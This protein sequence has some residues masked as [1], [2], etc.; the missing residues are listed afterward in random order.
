MGGGLIVALAAVASGCVIVRTTGRGAP[1]AASIPA[2]PSLLAYPEKVFEPPRR[3]D[4]RYTLSNGVPVYLAEDRAFPLLDVTVLIRA[5]SYLEPR[6]KVGLAGMTATVMRTGGTASLTAEEFDEAVDFLAAFVSCSLGDVEGRASAGCLSKDADRVLDLFFEML[7]RPRFEEDRLELARTQSL[8]AMRRRNDQTG[9][10]EAREWRR[11]MRGP[12]HFSSLQSTQASIE[13]IDRADL[14]AFHQKWV[15]PANFIIAVAGDFDRQAMIDTLERHL[16]DWPA[17]ERPPAPPKPDH[18]PRAG[19]YIVNKPDVNQGRVSI[20]HVGG[21]RDNP[22]R[23]ALRVMSHILGGGGFTSRILSRVRSDEGL[24][25]S[26]GAD[27]GLGV[28]YEGLFRASFQS[29][30]PACAEA[31]DIVLQEIERIR[32]EEVNPEELATAINALA[33]APARAF[34]DARR[35]V[36]TL[37]D[38]ELNGE[39]PDYWRNYAADLKA[40]TRADVL[41]VAR[42]YLA[43]DKLVI[44]IVGNKEDI[45]KGNPDRAA[46]SMG[47]LEARFGKLEDIPL[48]DPLTLE[49]PAS[50]P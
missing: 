16:A 10:I 17:G 32:A 46:Y 31:I 42:Q 24:A 13:A 21:R 27:Y 19:L 41:R 9:G 12:T 43:P 37:A 49:Y 8:Q 45:L 5:G 33:E 4:H 34:A 36:S 2:H 6:E 48:P 50:T 20:G 28:H 47:S 25:Y 29:R 15:Q 11:L 1:S 22:D 35:I 39:N 18:L 40:V 26:A 3:E 14:M 44:L 23:H 38:D 30:S 7:R